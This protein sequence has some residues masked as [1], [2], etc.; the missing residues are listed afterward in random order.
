MLLL[1]FVTSDEW[2]NWH[3]N[4]QFKA[5]KRSATGNDLKRVISVST[6]SCEFRFD[7]VQV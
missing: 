3:E 2:E 7:N 6:K 4:V 1:Y 5:Y